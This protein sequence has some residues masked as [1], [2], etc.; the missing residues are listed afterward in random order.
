MPR[1]VVPQTHGDSKASSRPGSDER[2]GLSHLCRDVEF[3]AAAGPSPSECMAHQIPAG[4]CAIFVSLSPVTPIGPI[5]KL[6]RLWQQGPPDRQSW[7]T[8]GCRHHSPSFPICR[9]GGHTWEDANH[10]A[11]YWGLR[12]RSHTR[13]LLLQ[14]M[15]PAVFSFHSE[16]D[17]S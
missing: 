10:A 17:K 16:G 7:G 5:S 1:T 2:Q 11:S 3:L 14:S 13:K 6:S 12:P 8:L 9:M 15:S 4:L